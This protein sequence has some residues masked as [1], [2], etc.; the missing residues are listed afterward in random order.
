MDVVKPFID[1]NYRTKSDFK[2]TAMIGSSLGGNITQFMGVEYENQISCLG[3]F[4]PL[5]G[6]IKKILIAISSVNHLN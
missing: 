2:H 3:V 4:H 1:E 6:F 5:I